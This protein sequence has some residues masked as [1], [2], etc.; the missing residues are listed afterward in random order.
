LPAKGRPSPVRDRPSAQGSTIAEQAST[1]AAAAPLL[2]I[3]PYV[4]LNTN[5]MS[6]VTSPNIVFKGANVHV[7]SASGETDSSGTGNLI[8]GW[9]ES[10]D[11][12]PS[13][14]RTGSN[15]LVLGN[16]NNYTSYG[17]LVG[18]LSSLI[19]GPYASVSGGWGNLANAEESSVTGG[20]GNWATARGASVSGGW[21]NTASGEDSSVSGGSTLTTHDLIGWKAGAYHSP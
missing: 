20:Y 17:G 7:M 16:Q 4:S 18:G 5:A 12:I 15:N 9:N 8:V 21:G 14:F 19:S 13:P 6:G 3:A 1:L 11:Y 2:A 10:P